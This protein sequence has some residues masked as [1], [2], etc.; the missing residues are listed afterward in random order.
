MNLGTA[1]NR[2]RKK[3]EDERPEEADRVTGKTDQ[4][5]H[6]LTLLVVP[7]LT[8]ESRASVCAVVVVKKMGWRRRRAGR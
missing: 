8:R 7:R 1:R 5:G 2:T 3:E 6:S 4:G